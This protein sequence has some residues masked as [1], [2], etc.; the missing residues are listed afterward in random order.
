[1]RARRVHDESGLCAE[2]SDSRRES[3]QTGTTRKGLGPEEGDWG[4]SGKT[5]K[6]IGNTQGK[7]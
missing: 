1:M 7:E 2:L 5:E 4:G 3:R 6:N